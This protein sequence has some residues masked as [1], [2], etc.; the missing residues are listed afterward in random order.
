MNCPSC[1]GERLAIADRQ[2]I[3]VDYCPACRGIWLERGELDKLLDR[4]D[5]GRQPRF[6]DRHQ[7]LQ[8]SQAVSV[9][10]PRSDADRLEGRHDGRGRSRRRRRGGL[11]SELLDFG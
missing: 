1:P 2:G 9:D 7:R 4:A 5:A 6:D 11:L 10:D 8:R 3:E